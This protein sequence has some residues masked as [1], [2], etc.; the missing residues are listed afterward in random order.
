V[1]R[2]SHTATDGVTVVPVL[3]ANLQQPR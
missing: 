2:R 1:T 3:N